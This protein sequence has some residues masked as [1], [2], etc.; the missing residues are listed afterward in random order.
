MSLLSPQLGGGFFTTEP[1]GK[2]LV[3]YNNNKK[4][5]EW[6]CGEEF[7]KSINYEVVLEM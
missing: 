5:E 7:M 3:P 1:S 4:P 6:W 2:P